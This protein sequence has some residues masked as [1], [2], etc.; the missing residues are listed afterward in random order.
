MSPDCEAW[1]AAAERDLNSCRILLAGNDY[2]AACFHAQQAVEK[3]LKALILRRGKPVPKVHSLTELF[4]TG[5]E[6]SLAVYRDAFDTMS[7]YYLPS[8]YPDVWTE[9]VPIWFDDENA[10]REAFNMA[11]AIVR[12]V[13]SLLRG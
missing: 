6:K 7:K 3:A 13:A 10:A 11:A 2:A 12:A 9:G 4:Q 1:F 8:R 5:G